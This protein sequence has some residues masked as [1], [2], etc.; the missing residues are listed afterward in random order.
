MSP[1]SCLE[2]SLEVFAG[3]IVDDGG[4]AAL[5]NLAQDLH[6]ELGL[7][8]AGVAH[9]LEVLGFLPE[10]NPHHLAQFGRLESD[11]VALLLPVE[12]LRRSNCG[13]RRMRPYFICL[14]RRM[15]YG[16]ANQSIRARQTAAL[17]EADGEEPARR[18]VPR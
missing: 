9:D 15:S 11:A 12:F 3:R 13:P 17:D 5:A 14:K 2:E 7:P 16:T 10:R 6:D 4:V 1:R 8:D 18:L